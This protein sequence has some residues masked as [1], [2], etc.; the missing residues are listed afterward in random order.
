MNESASTSDVQPT[1]T[2]AADSD[3]RRAGKKGATA[4]ERFSFSCVRAFLRA[5]L[6]L[7]GLRG[8]YWTCR[9]F[10]TAEY[11]VDYHRR[12]R[13]K[14]FLAVVYGKEFG[15]AARRRMVRE[16]FMRQRCD[17]TFY[18]IFD[19]LSLE[20]VQA[21]FRIGNR[22]LLEAGLA[23][24]RGVYVMMCHHGAFHIAGMA[25]SALG[26]R[27]G[28]VRDPKEGAVRR[29][30]HELWD[31]KHPTLPRIRMIFSGDYVRPIYR[32]F[33][34]NLIL[35]SSLDVARVRDP[36]LSSVKVN[37]FGQQRPF[38]TGTLQIALRCKATVVQ[39]LMT[40]GDDFCYRLDLVGPMSDPEQASE[41]PE[42]LASVMQRYADNI[43]DFVR[44]HP[45]HIHQL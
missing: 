38:L 2:P 13:V 39:G 31:K 35:G 37:F 33:Q 3:A 20:Q 28:G 25:L 6:T 41:T 12:R 44:K 9:L 29:F 45:D 14:R 26:Y 42:L 16:H 32:M 27:V 4:W 24:G 21:R 34:D 1:A 15:G 36:R 40:S 11:L 10:G 30:A 18:L 43:T 22:E 19:M 7:T 5:L 17:K 8:L 23:R